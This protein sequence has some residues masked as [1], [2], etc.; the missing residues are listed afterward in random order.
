[1]VPEE[2]PL[3]KR[4]SLRWEKDVVRLKISRLWK[5][6]VETNQDGSEKFS[7]SWWHDSWLGGRAVK[8]LCGSPNI[9]FIFDEN[10]QHFAA[11][12]CQVTQKKSRKFLERS[13]RK[14]ET[15]L[16]ISSGDF[17]F[18]STLST[19]WKKTKIEK[20]RQA[21]RSLA[22]GTEKEEKRENETTYAGCKI[23]FFI[24]MKKF[25]SCFTYNTINKVNNKLKL[26]LKKRNNY[27]EHPIKCSQLPRRGSWSQC[28]L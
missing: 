21:D 16:A 10:Y 23:F 5:S 6:L 27:F 9:P 13:H 14:R 19:S 2:L 25:R 18:W 15:D 11:N 24:Y 28:F 26:F 1:M 17:F 22:Q 7:A 12:A 8:I 3:C 20:T 4:K